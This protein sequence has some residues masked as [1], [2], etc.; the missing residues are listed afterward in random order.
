MNIVIANTQE[1]NPRIGGVE[2][3]SNIL[4][5][6][7]IKKGFNIY[8]IACFK[9][10]Y[11]EQYIT[12]AQQY[13]L[14]NNKEI[15]CEENVNYFK[16]FLNERSIDIVLNQAGNILDFSV[17]CSKSIKHTRI[18]LVSEIHI[19][20]LYRLQDLKDF[21]HSIIKKNSPLIFLL[22]SI[23]YPLYYFKIREKEKKINKEVSSF[24]DVVVLLSEYYVK[25]FLKLTNCK[26]EKIV[27]IPNPSNGIIDNEIKKKK[28]Q[29]LY[30]GRIIFEHKRTDRVIE[31]WEKLCLEFDDWEL[32]I[33]GDGPI[34]NELKEYVKTKKIPRIKFLGF[35]N[36]SKHYK[37][38]EIICMTSNFEGLPMVLIEGL[39]YN[40]IPISFDSFLSVYDVVGELNKDLVVDSFSIKEY[41]Q[42][43]RVL[44][45]SSE[46]R[47]QT[48]N[49]LNANI[50]KFNLDVIINQWFSLFKN[51]L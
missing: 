19:D 10:N 22:K 9:S 32:V 20:P 46:K 25:P 24:S 31:I 43:L 47:E 48:R 50:D 38:S 39:K 2:N 30:V 37:D 28:K 26:K 11:S 42:K 41:V 12:Q 14:P 34:L 36:P 4:A 51:L 45:D 33:A 29:L 49:S 7:L 6:E 3:V 16:F 27:V 18:K 40:C 23:R 1:F 15:L 5:E 13:F 17:L 8:F 44:M 35:C 21:G